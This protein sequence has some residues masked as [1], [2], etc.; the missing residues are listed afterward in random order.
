MHGAPGQ[1]RPTIT[2]PPNQNLACYFVPGGGTLQ[3]VD[4]VGSGYDQNV[5]GTSFGTVQ[6]VGN[7]HA[8]VAIAALLHGLAAHT[9]YHYAVVASD[10]RGNVTSTPDWTFT[11]H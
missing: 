8:A 3:G 5:L 4:F 7:G 1:P 6:Q 11:T 2:C 9:T 10:D